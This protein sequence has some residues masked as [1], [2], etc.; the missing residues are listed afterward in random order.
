MGK[1]YVM[2][3]TNTAMAAARQI[4]TGADKKDWIG[5]M[6]PQK[7][8]NGH[9]INF[10]GQNLGLWDVED[11]EIVPMEVYTDQKVVT[12]AWLNKIFEPIN[13]LFGTASEQKAIEESE[14]ECS[15]DSGSSDSDSSDD[16]SDSGADSEDVEAQIDTSKLDKAI[17]KGKAKKAKELLAKL[18]DGISK[19]DY[20]DYKK[21]IKGL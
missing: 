21:Q 15:N 4:K 7:I 5:Y 14:D 20:K 1:S 3:K 2:A 12:D 18:K 10:R 16:V 6:L 9:M 17:K 11:Q 8:E 13:K 19:A